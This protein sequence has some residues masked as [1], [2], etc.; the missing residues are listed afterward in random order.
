MSASNQIRKN[1]CV[2]ALQLAHVVESADA[3]ADVGVLR[4]LSGRTQRQRGRSSELPIPVLRH[5][6]VR[7]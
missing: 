7:L 3:T 5:N 6:S 4:L 2:F 1:A